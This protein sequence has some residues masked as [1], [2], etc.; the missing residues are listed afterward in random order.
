VNDRD[1]RIRLAAFDQCRRLLHEH[2]G[3]V[4]WG[5]IQRG[6]AFEGE[7]IHLGST[8]RGIHKPA[9]MQRGVLSIKTTKPM[10]GGI[11]RYDDALGD[12][13]YFSYAFQG[14]NPANHFNR[15]L[16][17]TF[18]DQSPFIYFY[19]LVPRIYE[20]LFPC[21]LGDWDP[22]AL[23]CTVAVGSQHDL[24]AQPEIRL[25]TGTID[26]RHTTIEAKVRLHQAEFRELVLGA[27]ER[28]CAI[29]NLPIPDLLQAAHIIP[30]RD[31]RG[32]PEVTNGLC[33]STLHHMAYD[34]NLVGIDPDGQIVVAPAV[35][36]QHDGPTL[37]QAIKGYHGQRIRV[38]KHA[39]DRPNRDYLAE[40]F[41]A[42]RQNAEA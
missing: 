27:Y 16:R 2:G 33:L 19:G 1:Q 8:P 38:P 32:R 4:P 41:E 29:S 14:D 24:R 30:D 9:R 31:E 12:D 21:Y 34:R 22:Q 37:E 25:P 17:E 20:I 36:E 15:A 39:G 42:F 3:A 5:A 40:R 23:R 7:R 35:L 26:R 10:Q 18:E 28:R 13:G 11:A 6:F